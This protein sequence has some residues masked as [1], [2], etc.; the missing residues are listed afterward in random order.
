MTFSCSATAALRHAKAIG[1]SSASRA[2]G[3]I[4]LCPISYERHGDVTEHRD[5]GLGLGLKIYQHE[6]L[7]FVLTAVFLEAAVG[8]GAE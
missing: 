6:G 3:T 1:T 7:T 5:G 8:R 4:P 2:P